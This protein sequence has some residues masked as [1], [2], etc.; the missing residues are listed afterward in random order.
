MMTCGVWCNKNI[1]IFNSDELT[2]V[3]FVQVV[4]RF[5]ENHLIRS[6]VMSVKCS[7][8]IVERY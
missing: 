3:V 7:F 2:W 1:Y 8:F 6:D 4:Y 5:D